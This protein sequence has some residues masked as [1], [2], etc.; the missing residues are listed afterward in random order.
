MKSTTGEILGSVLMMLA[1]IN[2][3]SA[4][5]FNIFQPDVSNIKKIK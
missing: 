4:C 3:E 5:V 2:L 1:M